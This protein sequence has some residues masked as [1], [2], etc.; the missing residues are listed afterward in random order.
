MGT[1]YTYSSTIYPT[2]IWKCSKCQNT[3]AGAFAISGVSTVRG[4][5]ERAKENA[6]NQLPVEI[7]DR[8]DN[9]KKGELQKTRITCKCQTCKHREE[10]A[11]YPYDVFLKGLFGI[12]VWTVPRRA[13]TGEKSP[14][15]VE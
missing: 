7:R 3:A 11:N 14:P 1:Y 13:D 15:V 8:I 12:P 9:I 5:R 2:V 6:Q 4:N 10:W